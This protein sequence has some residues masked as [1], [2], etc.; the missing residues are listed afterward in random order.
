MLPRWSPEPSHTVQA[1]WAVWWRATF[2]E[3][4]VQPAQAAFT[5][6]STCRLCDRSPP[7]PCSASFAAQPAATS[8]S[9][10]VRAIAGSALSARWLVNRLAMAVADAPS[11]VAP[12]EV[13]VPCVVVVVPLV[14]AVVLPPERRLVAVVLVPARFLVVEVE[15][16][17]S[18]RVDEVVELSSTEV[19]LDELVLA[20]VLEVSSSPWVSSATVPSP[21]SPLSNSATM[22]RNSVATT[23]SAPTP[24]S[25][26]RCG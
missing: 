26:R 22:P 14:G 7:G 16:E 24:T 3:L 10:A 4:A 18:G 23:T 19:L 12:E 15:L 11:A 1:P 8:S 5:W 25:A 9:A 17:A 20:R 2:S 21:P 13:V 6:E